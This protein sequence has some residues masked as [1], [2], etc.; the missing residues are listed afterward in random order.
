MV[1]TESNFATSI[2]KQNNL[3]LPGFQRWAFYPG[4]LFD[5]E[6]AWWG[7]GKKRARPHEGLDMCLYEDRQGTQHALSS[8]VRIPAIY[9]GLVVKVDDDFLGKSIYVKHGLFDS[10]G[11]VLFTAYGHTAPARGIRPGLE[12]AEGQVMATVAGDAGKKGAPPPH[13]H[14]SAVWVPESLGW[15]DLDWATISA[16]EAVRPVDPLGLL[17]LRYV[18]LE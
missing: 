12:V 10:S 16:R 7:D 4:M 17:G 15:D 9:E 13:L 14:I 6:Y 3:V 8:S 5:A 11:N 2:V 1:M 18:V